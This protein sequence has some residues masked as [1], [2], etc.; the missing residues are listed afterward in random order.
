MTLIELRYIYNFQAMEQY[1]KIYSS[2]Y[3]LRGK[4]F[5]FVLK[6]EVVFAYER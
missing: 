2:C 6:F 3:F 4:M 5:C 1:I